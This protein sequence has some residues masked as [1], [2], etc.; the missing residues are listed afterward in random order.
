MA[1]GVWKAR[2]ALDTSNSSSKYLGGAASK[3]YAYFTNNKKVSKGDSDQRRPYAQRVCKTG[4]AL[5]MILD[6]TALHLR[7]VLNGRQLGVAFEE[8]EACSYVAVVAMRQPNDCLQLLSYQ[9]STDTLSAA[10]DEQKCEH[11][12]KLQAELNH[13]KQVN[14]ELTQQIQVLQRRNAESMQQGKQIEEEYRK[15]N[16]ANIK[17]NEECKTFQMD[18]REMTEKYEAMLRKVNMNECNYLKWDSEMLCDWMLSLDAAFAECADKL[19]AKLKEEE[20]DGSQLADLDKQD[21]HRYGIR[22]LKHKNLIMQNIARITNR[23]QT[24][25][26]SLAQN[27]EGMN[28]ATA[29]I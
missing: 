18:L 4:D 29:Y 28:A 5:E 7:Y 26:T 12:H 6:L 15:M 19:R 22:T 14:T 11:C 9:T 16:E 3:C 10:E 1:I 21:L 13:L 24:A 17:L 20:V 23:D 27:D 8:I 25:S 2:H